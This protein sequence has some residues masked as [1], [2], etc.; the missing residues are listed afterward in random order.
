MRVV[1]GILFNRKKPSSEGLSNLLNHTQQGRDRSGEA[2][3]MEH[4]DSEPAVS[5]SRN[6][7]ISSGAKAS[8]GV[9]S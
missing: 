6:A 2:L 8:P 5:S 1:P 3:R 9:L 4:P 7:R